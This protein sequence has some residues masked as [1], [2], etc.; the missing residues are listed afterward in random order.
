MRV[1]VTFWN[2]CWAIIFPA[3]QS[4]SCRPFIKGTVDDYFEVSPNRSMTGLIIG[5]GDK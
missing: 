2:E 4:L 5:F 1:L 3:L